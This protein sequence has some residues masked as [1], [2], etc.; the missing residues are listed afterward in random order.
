MK[1]FLFSLFLALTGAH[2]G[3]L[4][5]GLRALT[6][7]KSV[8]LG[9]YAF[10]KG[11]EPLTKKSVADL[12]KPL[13]EAAGIATI[14]LEVEEKKHPG[15]LAQIP[16]LF[17]D[18]KCGPDGGKSLCTVTLNVSEPVS[19][20]RDQRKVHASTYSQSAAFIDSEI[21]GRSLKQMALL[22]VNTF[23]SQWKEANPAK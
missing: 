22:V 1:P 21:G 9:T 19:L 23:V 8:A 3:E 7:L 14:P 15:G 2:G 13:L 18:A 20:A 16:V 12:A 4:D 17:V 5:P 11:A 6:G 10:Q